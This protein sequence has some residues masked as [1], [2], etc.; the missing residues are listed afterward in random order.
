MLEEQLEGL[1]IETPE[2]EV[3]IDYENKKFT[4]YGVRLQKDK[5]IITVDNKNVREFVTADFPDEMDFNSVDQVSEIINVVRTTG[6]RG[7][8]ARYSLEGA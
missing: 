6:I 5:V 8:I 3:V 1:N 4:C 7:L 2:P